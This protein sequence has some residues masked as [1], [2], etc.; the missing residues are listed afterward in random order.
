MR[1]EARRRR[2]RLEAVLRSMGFVPYRH[3]R[4]DSWIH[5]AE[6][7][8]VRRHFAQQRQRRTFVLLLAAR[9][10]ALRSS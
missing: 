9:V 1:A 2:E 10:R 3:K 5:S 4:D 8:R 6:L 7:G